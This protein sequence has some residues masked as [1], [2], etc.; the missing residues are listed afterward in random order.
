MGFKMFITIEKE[1]P[2]NKRIKDFEKLD[3]NHRRILMRGHQE[4][5]KQ[6]IRIPNNSLKN[7][8]NR[9]GE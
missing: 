2:P 7:K 5:I 1:S 3:Y 4:K 8:N 6:K 9:I